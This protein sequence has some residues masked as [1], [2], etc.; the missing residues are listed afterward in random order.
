MIIKA[1]N[2]MKSKN[3]AAV[4]VRE[5]KDL[6]CELHPPLTALIGSFLWKDPTNWTK[7]TISDERWHS[8]VRKAFEAGESVLIYRRKKASSKVCSQMI[9]DVALAASH[10]DHASPQVSSLAQKI[11]RGVEKESLSPDALREL[12]RRYRSAKA[13][14]GRR[15]AITKPLCPKMDIELV[16]GRHARRVRTIRDLTSLKRYGYCVGE[17]WFRDRMKSGSDAYFELLEADG[18]HTALIEFDT[19]GSSDPSKWI[20]TQAKAP[21]NKPISGRAGSLGRLLRKLGCAVDDDEA[22]LLNAGVAQGFSKP[23]SRSPDHVLPDGSEICFD[24]ND[25]LVRKGMS[26]GVI[27]HKERG[28]WFTSADDFPGDAHDLLAS[29]FHSIRNTQRAKK[30]N[31]R[32]LKTAYTR[33]ANG[34]SN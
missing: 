31:R 22:D 14:A 18:S 2:K 10:R 9:R 8:N 1:D 26:L 21:G 24:G 11:V 17:S 19:K 33:M 6:P 25:V 5:R 34:S 7:A 30:R 29:A 27:R 12:Q 32:R 20:C 3:G 23:L 16:S 13:R 15:D 28:A 4:L